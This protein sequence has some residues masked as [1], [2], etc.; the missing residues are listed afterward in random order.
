MTKREKDIKRKRVARW[1]QRLESGKYRQAQMVLCI[2]DEHGDSFCCL[3]LACDQAKHALHLNRTPLIQEEDGAAPM[4][5][6]LFDGRV[7]YLPPSV[8]QYFGFRTD[9]GGC[10]GPGDHLS[11]LNDKGATFKDIAQHVR[12]H[13]RQYF[14][15]A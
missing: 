10:L 7:Y 6:Q 5:S 11:T 9:T 8:M 1:L 4:G 14:T 2:T 12:A 15:W 3:G 13:L